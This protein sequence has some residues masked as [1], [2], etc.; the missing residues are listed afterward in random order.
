MSNLI[1]QKRLDKNGLLVTR[2]VKADQTVSKSTIPAPTSPQ[3]AAQILDEPEAAVKR[4]LNAFFTPSHGDPSMYE[5]RDGSAINDRAFSLIMGTLPNDTLNALSERE[6]SM[7]DMEK[8][9][10]TETLFELER[11]HSDMLGKTEYVEAMVHYSTELAPVLMRFSDTPDSGSKMHSEAMYI[12][13]RIATTFRGRDGRLMFADESEKSVVRGVRSL[14][15]HHG[16]TQESIS[17]GLELD[18]QAP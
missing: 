14:L 8:E 9:I 4:V 2:H 11:R 17:A 13:S 6:A 18:R 3:V 16:R 7:P 15:S 1:P 5:T 10:V 12:N